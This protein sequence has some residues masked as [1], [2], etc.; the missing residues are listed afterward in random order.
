MAKVML[1]TPLRPY[2]DKQA[3]VDISG[4]TVGEVLSGLTN[5]FP[6]L[7]KHLF[8]DD[9][10]LRS[11]V[12]LYVDEEDIRYQEGLETKL[13]SAAEISIIPSIAGG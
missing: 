10:K 9:G 1:P 4:G 2:A 8:G 5:Q 12:N 13:E 3:E 11:F 7:K 6:D